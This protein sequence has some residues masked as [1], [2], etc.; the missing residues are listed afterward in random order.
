MLELKAV[1]HIAATLFCVGLF[2]G[3]VVNPD[4]DPRLG[5]G[6]LALLAT[7]NLVSE[8]C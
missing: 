3:S 7:H 8:H 5:Y 1:L 6:L 4:A 2:W